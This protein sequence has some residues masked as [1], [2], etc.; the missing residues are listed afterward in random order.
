METQDKKIKIIRDQVVKSKSISPRRP[1]FPKGMKEN[2][3]ALLQ[4]GIAAVDLAQMTGLSIS[5]LSRWG[6]KPKATFHKV[7][8]EKSLRVIST[9]DF[10]FKLTMPNG[11]VLESSSE[12]VFKKLFEILSS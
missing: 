5:S 11:S 12:I 7:T 6:S 1:N 8:K 10:N 2:V 3:V 4:S 9:N